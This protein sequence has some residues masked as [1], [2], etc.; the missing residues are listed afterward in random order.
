VANIEPQVF[1]EHLRSAAA[2]LMTNMLFQDSPGHMIWELDNLLRMRYLG[3]VDARKTYYGVFRQGPLSL[4]WH[5]ANSFPELFNSNSINRLVV[6]DD[7]WTS[8]QQIYA[9]APELGVDVGLSHFKTALPNAEERRLARLM[10]LP[11]NALRL[12]WVLPHHN[13]YGRT[14]EYFRR[15]AASLQ[16]N[17]WSKVPPLSE[18]L[19]GFVG[20]G[21]LALIHIRSV[22]RGQGSAGNAGTH[23]N[24]Q[25]FGPTLAMLRDT[26]YT[27]VK[28]GYE[29]YPEE[30]KQFGV[31]NYTNSGLMN[32]SNDLRLLGAAKLTMVN[33]SGF[34][35]FS[36]LIGTPMVSY[37]RWSIGQLIP[38]KMTVHLPTLMRDKDTGKL[39]KFSEQIAHGFSKYE[40][41]ERGNCL[42]FPSDQFEVRP[43][44]AEELL[45]SA[46]E[47]IRL[48]E[49]WVP[50]SPL[51]HQFMELG[52]N[53]FARHIEGR[54]S[55]DFLERFS[56]A[57][58][59][60]F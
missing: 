3:E 60:G 59:L 5:I 38:G 51:Q 19:S 47:A 6:D 32:Y 29:P 57:L 44:H 24:S 28:V 9:L 23:T 27:V 46:L 1:Y 26:G 55:Q 15:R 53:S 56:A 4:P 52:R 30:W 12:T 43:V 33:A 18:E 2:G 54:V 50:P 34:E 10:P 25:V 40:F 35:N 49:Q 45:A 13:Y 14:L 20:N 31:L 36:D 21:K 58:P 17:P 22:L 39:L 41:W 48:G 16:F 37:G 8:V 11:G 7:L 42:N